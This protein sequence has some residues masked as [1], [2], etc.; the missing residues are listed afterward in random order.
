MTLS[1]L[2]FGILV[3]GAGGFAA[4]IYVRRELPIPGRRLLGTIRASVLVL[5]LL[6]LWDPRLPRGQG[7]GTSVGRWVLLDASA[8]MSAATSEGGS[9]WASTLERAG[10]LA[11]AGAQILLFGET[12]RVVPLDALATL[13]PGASASRLAPALARAAE[14]GATDVTVLSDLRLDDPVEVELLSGR[15]PF[16]VEIE[17]RGGACA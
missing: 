2:A 17:K 14:A 6:L 13:L 1:W 7:S 5:V 10:E 16:G 12:P 3:A 8:S 4:W 15:S 11:R 9:D